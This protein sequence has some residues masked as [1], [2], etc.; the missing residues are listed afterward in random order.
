MKIEL[1]LLNEINPLELAYHAND[2]RI[3]T[4]LR[5]S[6]PYPYTLDHAID[7]INNCMIH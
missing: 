5:N 6:F 1:K 3:S 2:P 7:F 4:Y